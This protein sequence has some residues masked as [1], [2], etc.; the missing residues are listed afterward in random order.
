MSQSREQTL[1]RKKK[2]KQSKRPVFAT[3]YDPRLPSIQSI[4][5]KH[6]RSMVNQDQYLAEV[7]EQPPLTGFKRQPNIR[8]HLIRAK[9]PNTRKPYPQRTNRGMNKCGRECPACPFIKEQRKIKVN[10]KSDWKIMKQVNC[11]SFN[12]VY[13]IECEKTKCNQKYIGETKRTLK[14]RLADHRGY[15]TSENLSTAT[16]AHFNSTGHSLSDMK[17]SIIEQVKK[18]DD[19]YRKQREH[20]HIEKFNTFNRG[21]NKQK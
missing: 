21:L 5:A 8:N 9:L 14:S 18:K 4:Q 19:I 20:Y 11:N 6:H 3:P 7:F 2:P 16:G 1:K 12:V 15:I 13:M 17:I 10:E